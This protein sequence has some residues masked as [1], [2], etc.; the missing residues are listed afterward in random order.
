MQPGVVLIIRHIPVGLLDMNSFL[1]KV[2]VLNRYKSVL[3]IVMLYIS[4]GRSDCYGFAAVSM[5]CIHKCLQQRR[6]IA[7]LLV[8][9]SDSDA[10]QANGGILRQGVEFLAETGINCTNVHWLFLIVRDL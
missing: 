6:P 9:P 3:D 7:L 1:I 5:R 4:A 2:L 10:V 8:I